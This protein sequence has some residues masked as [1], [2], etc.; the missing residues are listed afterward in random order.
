[1]MSIS[2]YS[3]VG[4]ETE[5][6]QAT[7]RFLTEKLSLPLAWRAEH[8]EVAHFRLPSG[9]LFE[10][11]GPGVTEVHTTSCPVIGFDV[12]DVRTTQ[13]ELAQRGVEFI[14]EVEE[15]EDGASWVYFRGPDGQLYQLQRSREP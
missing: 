15:T 11:F 8:A 10:V 3:W 2:G 4:I 1:M 13:E 7:I 5:D 6:F 14:T 12:E 9:Q